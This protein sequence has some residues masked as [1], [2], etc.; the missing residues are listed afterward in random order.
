MRKIYWVVLTIIPLFILLTITSC[1]EDEIIEPDVTY[2]PTPYAFDIPEWVAV[3]IGEI[4]APIDNPT[5]IA[6]V[7][8]GRALFYDERLSNDMTMSC[9]T[10]HKQANAFDDPRPFSQGTNGAFGN[11]NAMAIINLAWDGSFFWDGRQQSLEAQAHDPVTN[12]IEMA[13]TWVEIEN[14]LREDAQYQD[15]FKRAFNTTVIDSILIT[16]AIAQFERTLVSF[17]SP[18]DAYYYGG[19]ATALTS[20]EISGMNL[21]FGDAKCFQCHSDP[22][23]TDNAFRNNGLDLMPLDSGRAKFTGLDADYGKFKVTT[24]RNIANTAPYMHDSRFATLEQVVEHYSSG[25]IQESPNLDEHMIDFGS[26]LNLT[27]T[28]KMQLVAFL[29]TL[30]DNDFLTNQQYADPE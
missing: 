20:D 22:L 1:K 30:S 23:F 17:D 27:A 29:Q 14:R 25:V 10:C 3:N 7:E 15:M 16:K 12:P 28:E 11:R 13:N 4:S 8:L 21:F 18:F 6:G 2:D 24:L 5:T 26:G 9:G 19:D